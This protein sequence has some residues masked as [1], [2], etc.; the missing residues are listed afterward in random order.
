MFKALIVDDEKLIRYGMLR[1]IPWE[2]LGIDDVFLAK[3]GHEALAIIRERKPDILIS[4]IKMDAM[5][6]LELISEAKRLIPDMR[7]L[8]LTGYDDFEYARRCIQLK[9]NDFFLKPIDEDALVDA[10]RAQIESLAKSKKILNKSKIPTDTE[11]NGTEGDSGRSPAYAMHG[12]NRG[13]L[14]N[15]VFAEI[16][17]EVCLNANDVSKVISVFEQFYKIVGTY[18]LSDEAICRYCFELASSVFFAFFRHTGKEADDRLGSYMNSI[19]N[20]QPEEQLEITRLFLINLLDED[21]DLKSHGIIEKA[22]RYIYDNLSQELSVTSIAAH[23][24]VTPNYL[25]RLFK[26]ITGEGCY[27]YVIRKRMEKAIL[28]LETTNL[29]PH[30]I[31]AMTGYND[32]N[33]FSIAIKKSTGMSP[34]RYRNEFHKKMQ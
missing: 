6:G 30:K 28:L 33:Y 23:I 11:H 1:A 4:D 9:V 2:N 21:D 10:I 34:Q 18:S 3:S 14:F 27:E 7:V 17:S 8:V 15:D 22:K 5:S 12:R 26:R 32:T 20:T 25:S 24:Y 29:K 16:K 31:A 13:V 19:I